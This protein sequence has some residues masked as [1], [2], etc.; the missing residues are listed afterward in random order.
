MLLVSLEFGQQSSSVSPFVSAESLEPQVYMT[1]EDLE[2]Y[3]WI[4]SHYRRSRLILRT[5]LILCTFEYFLKQAVQ[6]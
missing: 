4:Q 1:H 3:C 5:V 6:I 2:T